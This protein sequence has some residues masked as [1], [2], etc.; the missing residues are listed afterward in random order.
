MVPVATCGKGPGAY[1]KSP[2]NSWPLRDTLATGSYLGVR[3]RGYTPRLIN[4]GHNGGW[5]LHVRPLITCDQGLQDLPVPEATLASA[6][7]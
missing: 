3:L 6:R 5:T 1:V 7:G 2:L 4:L